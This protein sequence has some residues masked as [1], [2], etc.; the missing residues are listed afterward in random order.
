M[1]SFLFFGGAGD[2][3]RTC[4]RESDEA[5]IDARESAGGVLLVPDQLLQQRQTA[6]TVFLRPRD[7]R[8]P[9][10]PLSALPGQVE[11][12]YPGVVARS[13][14]DRLVLVEPGPDPVAELHLISREIQIHG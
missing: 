11:L 12:A 8:P 13:R 1:E 14:F 7:A 6:A 2:Q 5:G 4:V 3:G 10:V 9:A